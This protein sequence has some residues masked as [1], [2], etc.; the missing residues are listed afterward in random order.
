MSFP[1]AVLVESVLGME[2]IST[3]LASKSEPTLIQVPLEHIP[4]SKLSA[5]LITLILLA[6]MNSLIVLVVQGIHK[7]SKS[8]VVS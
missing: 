2:V 6:G 3:V 5:T 7:V 1:L 8:I 4:Q